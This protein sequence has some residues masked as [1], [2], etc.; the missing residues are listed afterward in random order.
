[1]PALILPVWSP[2]LVAPFIGSF[3]GVLIQ[4]LP[5]HRPFVLARSACATCGATLGPRD[6]IPLAS[7]AL[8]RGRCRHCGGAIS[9]FHP[10]IELA[11]F[12]VAG[13]SM[14][15]CETPQQAWI[16]CMLGWT[17]LTL[18]WIDA[19][20][21]LLPDLLTLPLLL[22]GLGVAL[23]T[24]PDAVFWHALGAVCGYLGLRGVALAYRA[25]RGRDGMGAGDA[26]LL[27]AAGAWLGVGALPSLLLL[28]AVAGLIWAGLA[29]LAGRSMRATTV[30]PFGPFLAASFW[31][32][33]LYRPAWGLV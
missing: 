11:A 32:L 5:A 19:S 7:F 21:F 18:A 27:A 24:E 22:A 9:W 13:W 33:W 26:K 17:L 16:G 2:L 1:M 23:A 15:S 29:A 3:L 8:Q 25:V 6:L 12:G 30:L 28:S 20:C 10:A 4:R 14:F 31:L